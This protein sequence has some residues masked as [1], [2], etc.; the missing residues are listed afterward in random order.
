MPA[1]RALDGIEEAA[2]RLA[3]G[4][5]RIGAARR[6]TSAGGGGRRHARSRYHR[7]DRSVSRNTEKIRRDD[8][9]ARK[10]RADRVHPRAQGILLARFRSQ[11]GGPDSAAGDASSSSPRRWSLSPGQPDARVLDI[12][13]GSGAI[14]I[15][16]AVNAPR[17]RVTAVDISADAIAVASRN[18]EHHRVEDRVTLRRADCF[19]I[20]D[21]GPALGS[22]E[23]DSLQSALPG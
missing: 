9:A 20:L 10:A 2:R 14:A 3:A 4:G 8:R 5:H 16:I 18:A 23:R 13:T 7:F 12:G 19:D 15:A 6:G 17:T 1:R 22:F 21:G 11:P